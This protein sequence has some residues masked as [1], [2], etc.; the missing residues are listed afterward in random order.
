MLAAITVTLAMTVAAPPTESAPVER[1]LV[2]ELALVVPGRDGAELFELVDA[3]LGGVP[4]FVAVGVER[5]W[6]PAA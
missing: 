1:G 2:H 3:L 6:P 4:L 5:R